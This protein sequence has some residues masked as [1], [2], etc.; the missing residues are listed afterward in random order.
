LIKTE[1]LNIVNVEPKGKI[2]RAN[3]KITV[4]TSV[5]AENGISICGYSTNKNAIISNI[6]LFAKTNST[7]HEQQLRDLRKGNYNYYITC[8]D[9]AGN[10]DSEALQFEIAAD[11]SQPVISYVYKD[12]RNNVLVLGTNEDSSC[13]YDTKQISF[14]EGIPM[15]DPNSRKHEAVLPVRFY[16]LVCK[17][18][19]NNEEIIT[20][21]P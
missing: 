3:P 7:D 18:V 19:F 6:P 21:Y 15:T 5:G 1:K 10:I 17:D 2:F 20:V 8:I 9:R 11:V 4:K 14:G 16:N 12:V 13:F